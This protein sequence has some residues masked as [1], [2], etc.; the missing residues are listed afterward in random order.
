MA[1]KIIWTLKAKNELIEIFQY[2]NERNQSTNFSQKLNELINDQLNSISQFP[3]SGKKQIL[4][5]FT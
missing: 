3:K 5:K 4:K 1:R 2:W